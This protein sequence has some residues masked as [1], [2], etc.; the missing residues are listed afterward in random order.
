MPTYRVTVRPHITVT[1]VREDPPPGTRPYRQRVQLGS[2]TRLAEGFARQLGE[3]AARLLAGGRPHTVRMLPSGDFTVAVADATA[4][5]SPPPVPRAC[6]VAP[7]S[8]PPVP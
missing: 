4:E 6:P 3:A 5:A 8:V 7:P 1:V 2:P